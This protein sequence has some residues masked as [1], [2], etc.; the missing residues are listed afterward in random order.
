MPPH[1]TDR[2]IGVFVPPELKAGLIRLAAE[3]EQTVSAVIRQ[4]VRRLVRRRERAADAA[5]VVPR[6]RPRAEPVVNVNE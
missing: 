3:R 1:E 6:R 2:F 5:P 4:A